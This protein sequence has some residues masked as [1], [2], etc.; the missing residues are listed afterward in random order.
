MAV[1]SCSG[2]LTGHRVLQRLSTNETTRHVGFATSEYKVRPSRKHA[3][4]ELDSPLE[5]LAGVNISAVVN[6]R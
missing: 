1:V 3:R 2:A 5:L 6:G 4:Y